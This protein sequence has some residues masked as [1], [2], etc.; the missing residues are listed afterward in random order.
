MYYLVKTPWWLKKLYPGM[1]WNGP[2]KD[3]TIYLTFDDGPH[4]T[5]TEFVINELR[6][7]E[8]KAT[9]FCI[10]ENVK[11]YPEMYKN[12]IE[13]GHA[14]G[15]HTF[16]HLNGWRTADAEY[17]D[18]IAQASLFIDSRLFRPP[19]G[20]I[21]RFQQQQ[22]ANPR[23]GLQTIMWSVVS[24]DF[25]AGISPKR[26]LKNVLRNSG[27]GSI[28]VFHDSEKAWERLEYAL[29]KVL[30]YFSDK[31]FRFGKIDGNA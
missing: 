25:D 12:L 5:I 24:G 15:N 16:N 7:F 6:K 14:V 31:G 4:P 19:Y 23:F 8:A 28:V 1:T 2:E 20:K 11:K 17:L 18:N 13:E 27:E 29:P 21:T 9:F 22:L 10:G 3:K 30:N 26:C